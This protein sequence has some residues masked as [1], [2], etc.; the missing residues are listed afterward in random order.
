MVAKLT[1]GTVVAK[2]AVM[3]VAVTVVAEAVAEDVHDKPF[4]VSLTHTF[5]PE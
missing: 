5:I 1:F 3:V 2:K 4:P